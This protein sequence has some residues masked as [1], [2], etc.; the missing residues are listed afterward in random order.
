M[1]VVVVMTNDRK[2][3][4]SRKVKGRHCKQSHYISTK[5]TRG[6]YFTFSLLHTIDP[7]IYDVVDVHIPQSHPRKDTDSNYG[8]YYFMTSSKG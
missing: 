8:Y 1:Y 4:C 6:A 2:G 7:T 3:R 5:Y